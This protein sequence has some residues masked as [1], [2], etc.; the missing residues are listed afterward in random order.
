MQQLFNILT[1]QY[2]FTILSCFSPEAVGS[3]DIAGTE[4]TQKNHVTGF[5]GYKIVKHVACCGACRLRLRTSN[6]N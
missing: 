6:E 4:K 5:F 3:V 1:V 2:L